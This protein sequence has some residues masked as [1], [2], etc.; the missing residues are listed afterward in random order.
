MRPVARRTG[1]VVREL[2]DEV[3]VYDTATH[4][5][6]CLNRTAALVYRNADGSRTVPE[7]ARLLGDDPS[8]TH[9]AVEMALAALG[10]ARLLEGA[11]VAE[12]GLSRRD[13]MRR[14][15]LGAVLLVPAIVSVLAP[16]PAEAAAT[17]TNDCLGKPNG[18]PCSCSG[19][20]PCTATCISDAC[21]DGGGC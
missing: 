13:V 1:L 20:N 8:A 12:A 19:A 11:A 18:T 3:V 21:S 14:A 15:S 9:A 2:A 6:H 5:A 16:T 4:Q 7:L 17:C 10:E